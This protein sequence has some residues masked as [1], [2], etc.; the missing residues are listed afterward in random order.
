[1][2]VDLWVQEGDQCL[3]L[4]KDSIL[5][6]KCAPS[7][8]RHQVDAVAVALPAVVLLTSLH[9]LGHMWCQCLLASVTVARVDDATAVLMLWP[10]NM[11]STSLSMAC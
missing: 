6:A 8:Q 1:M 4:A 9:K 7:Q 5:A 11:L 2:A 3:Q 10:C